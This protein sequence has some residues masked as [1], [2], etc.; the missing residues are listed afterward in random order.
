MRDHYNIIL[1]DGSFFLYRN[2]AIGHGSMSG[3]K[4][5]GSFM[6]SITKLVRES[7]FTFDVGFL[8]FDKKPYHRTQML[9]GKYKDSREEYSDEDIRLITEQINNSE[10]EEKVKLE[11]YKSY[12]LECIDKLNVRLEAIRI[13]SNL[14]KFGLTTLSYAGYE[15]DDIARIIVNLYSD[16]YSILLLSIDSDWAGLVSENVD[17][18]RVRHRGIRDFYD[19]NTIK[20]YG[21]YVKMRDEGLEEMGLAWYLQVQE[22]MGIGHN[23]MRR[24]WDESKP[25]TIGELIANWDDLENLKDNYNFDVETFWRQFSTFEVNKFPDYGE[26]TAKILSLQYQLED[27]SKFNSKFIY[28]LC[29]GVNFNYYR[30]LYERVRNYSLLQFHW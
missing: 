14:D 9:G 27:P 28:E 8:A 19:L 21:D 29:T 17:Y 18:L 15:A 5:A 20:S 16:K 13:L 23:D 6:Q 30:K 22:A 4:L 2:Q 11:N 1:V 3:P 10:G 7:S 24:C 25:V 26:I 12:M